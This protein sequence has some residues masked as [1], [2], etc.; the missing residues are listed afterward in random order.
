MTKIA[1][2]PGDGIGPEVVREALKVLEIVEKKMEK[3]FEKVFGYIGGDAI[4]KFGEPL[5]EE[6]KKICLEADAIFLGS[7][8]GPKWDDLPPQKRP[9]IGGLLALRKMLNLYANIRPIRVYKSLVTIS[10]LKE[11]VI[12]DGVDLVTV[13]ELSYGVYYGEPRGIDEEKGFDTM[14]YDRK[15]VERIARTAFKIARSRRKKVTSVDKANVL[16]SSMLWRK[17]V[18]EVAVEYPDVELS[19]MYV[20]NAAM[21]LVLKPSQFDV[22][23]T[24]N[25]FGDIISDESA[26]LP[27][28]LGLL[29]SASFGDKNLYEPAGGSAPDI[30]GKNVAN[31]IAQILSLAMMLEYSFGMAEVARKIERAV[32]MVID[33][34][35]RTKDIADDPEKAVSTSRMGDLICRKLEEIW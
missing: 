31:P 27:G 34:G 3:K 28:S 20:D 18:S 26:A 15:T 6:T 16:Y 24:T 11:E 29:P 12:R 13:R 30:A 4:D 2:L 32:E 33:E 23:L 19:H 10:P 21:Q 35:Y 1:I 8:G 5:P 14:I 17:V 9:E 25:M 7:V 22:I